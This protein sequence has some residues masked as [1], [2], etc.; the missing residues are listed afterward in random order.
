[1][2][3][4]LI[5]HAEAVDSPPGA[6]FLDDLRALTPRGGRRFRK[7]ARAF[8]ELGETI[9]AVRSSPA[10]RA[11]ETAELLAA[12]IERATVV[13]LDELRPNVAAVVLRDWL[14]AQS[15]GSIALVGH[16]RQLRDLARLLIGPELPFTLKKG[17][18]I[19]IDLRGKQAVSRWRLRDRE[20]E[21]ALSA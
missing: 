6:R 4:Y 15:E 2:R 13:V 17:C 8:A 21:V 12:Q 3:L 18:I 19:R 5:R 1:M 14:L 7:T 10:L 16:G 20:R 9:A 11:V